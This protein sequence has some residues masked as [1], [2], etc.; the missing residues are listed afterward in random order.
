MGPLCY[1]LQIKSMCPYTA[2]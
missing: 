2:E 1:N